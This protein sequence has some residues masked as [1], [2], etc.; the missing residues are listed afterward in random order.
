MNWETHENIIVC[1]AKGLVQ[2][3]Q[4]RQALEKELDIWSSD[5]SLLSLAYVY[6][7]LMHLLDAIPQEHCEPGNVVVSS[8]RCG[9]PQ[10]VAVVA[11]LFMQRLQSDIAWDGQTGDLLT[12]GQL[13]KLYLEDF[14][15]E[16][17]DRLANEAR[18]VFSEGEAWHR[19]HP[20]VQIG[21]WKTIAQVRE[22]IRS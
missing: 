8:F 4:A 22:A 3:D 9:G 6:R 1:D 14:A 2:T 16:S 12:L 19:A 7:L 17:R 5:D 18:R 13:E 20:D 21:W 15:L 11:R 10:L